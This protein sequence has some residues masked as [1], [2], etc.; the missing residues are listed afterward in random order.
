MTAVGDPCPSPGCHPRPPVIPVPLSSPTRSGIHA[1]RLVDSRS[2]G[3]DSSRGSMPLSWLSSP[4]PCH[5]RPP[6][7]PV[8]LSSPSPCHPRPPVIPVP[9]SSPS[10]C[11]PRPPVIPIP[12]SSPTRSGIH[13]PRLVDSRSVG[14]DR[15]EPAF[16]V[17]A[18]GKGIPIPTPQVRGSLCHALDDAFL[19]SK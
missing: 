9:L 12:L 7:T 6:V 16:H 1:P 11:H 2:V 8:P 5:P 15:R 10:P 17:D 18:V 19:T 13:A 14:N 3:N 4:S